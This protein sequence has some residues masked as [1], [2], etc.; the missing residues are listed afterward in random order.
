MNDLDH[1]VPE[2]LIILAGRK[3]YA[4]CKSFVMYIFDYFMIKYW[5]MS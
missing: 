5:P 1:W 2:K 3:I 4:T